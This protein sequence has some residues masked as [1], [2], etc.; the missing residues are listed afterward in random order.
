M[1]IPKLVN[2]ELENCI[3]E[4]TVVSPPYVVDFAG[5]RLTRPDPSRTKSLSIGPAKSAKSSAKTGQESSV[6]YP[7]SNLAAFS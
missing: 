1:P 6:S 2:Y 3:I 4:M 7:H 5:A